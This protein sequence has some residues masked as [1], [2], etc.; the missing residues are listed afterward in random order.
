M[1]I[2]NKTK[3]QTAH[4]AAFIRRIAADELSPE[5]RKR[6]R[7]TITT[8]RVSSWRVAKKG[9]RPMFIG[10][11]GYAWIGSCS[12][13]VRIPKPEYLTEQNRIDFCATLAHEMHHIE[14]GAGG[15]S[16]EINN[17]R[18]VPYGRPKDEAGRQR[19]RELYAWALTLPLEPRPVLAKIRP[20]PADKR[21]AIAAKIAEWERRERRCKT[22]LAKYRRR[23]RYYDR[24]IAACPVAPIV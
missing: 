19:Q 5:K 14:T 23:L 7:A 13:V 3:Y 9:D 18:N 24:K 15:R 17:R 4:L 6:L 12:I 16:W 20:G 21:E 8:S 2:V 11:S 1:K 10:S 22:A